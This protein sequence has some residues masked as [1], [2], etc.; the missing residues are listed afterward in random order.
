MNYDLSDD[1]LR[2]LDIR[3]ISGFFAVN[4][5]LTGVCSVL[6]SIS[7]FVDLNFHLLKYAYYER[8]EME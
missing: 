8:M 2:P 6:T 4:L 5:G 1:I 3:L 7:D